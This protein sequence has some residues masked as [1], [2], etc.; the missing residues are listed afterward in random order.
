M[1]DYLLP[2]LE[3]TQ[4]KILLFELTS[5]LECVFSFAINYEFHLLQQKLNNVADDNWLV[6]M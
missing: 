4:T 3:Q 1:N 2:A 5:G 6:L